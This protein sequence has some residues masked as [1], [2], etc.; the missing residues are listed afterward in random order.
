MLSKY[1]CSAYQLLQ[2]YNMHQIALTS[3]ILRK[4]LKQVLNAVINYCKLYKSECL[5]LLV[6]ASLENWAKI[7]KRSMDFYASVH[8]FDTSR[9]MVQHTT[10]HCR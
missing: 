4:S 2:N 6:L 10:K 8:L 7:M 9:P 5:L 3:K 1:N